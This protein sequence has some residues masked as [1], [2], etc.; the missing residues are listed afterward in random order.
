M[1]PV[2]GKNNDDTSSSG[3]SDDEGKDIDI[4]NLVMV[5]TGQFVP[6]LVDPGVYE[7]GFDGQGLRE[8][9]GKCTWMDGTWYDGGWKGG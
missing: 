5:P 3:N 8:G 4:N 6:M 9:N 1:A 7:G 2:Y